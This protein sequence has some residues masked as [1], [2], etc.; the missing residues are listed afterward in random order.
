MSVTGV[1]H[2]TDEELV[3]AT[4]RF[5]GAE[6]AATAAL[7][8]HLAEIEA[9]GVH[10][11][12]GYSSLYG[13]CRGR[14]GL[15]EHASYNRMEAARAA[16]RFPV[17]VP[18]LAEGLLHLTTVRLLAPRLGD[19]DHLALLGGAARKSKEEVRQQLARWFPRPDVKTSIRRSAIDP[20]SGDSYS[21]KLTAR[22]RTVERLRRAQ[23]LLSHAV[24]AGDVDEIL[25]RALG[26]LIEQ[27]GRRRPGVLPRARA[28]ATGGKTV[29]G[30]AGVTSAQEMAGKPSR[31]VPADVEREVR[32]RDGN[33]CDFV[34]RDGRRCGETR[35]VELHH[36][37]PWITGS[38]PTVENLGLRCRAHNQHE[39]KVWV[40]PIRREMEARDA[41]PGSA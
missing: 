21:V 33:A 29:A 20:R 10:L 25:Y 3:A 4:E 41:L 9:R 22:R 38:P 2:L 12:L 6:R 34:G 8:A 37:K 24:P 7:I 26:A 28:R 35:F 14:L 27:E 39:W 32:E 5:C 36:R 15:A 23:E 40:A 18:M 17:I 1:Q 31:Y 30:A 16:R 13:Y 19:A 11:A